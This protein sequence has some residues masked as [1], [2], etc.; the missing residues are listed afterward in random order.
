MSSILNIGQTALA[1][2]QAGL[3]TT[4]H[5][6]ANASTPGYNRQIV[7]QAAL[8]GQN[9]GFGFVGRGTEIASI[10]RVYSDFL[11]NQVV[12]S[13]SA[14]SRLDS[15][16]T[17]AKYIDSLVAD[18]KTGVS[19]ALQNF[20]KSVQNISGSP[21]GAEARQ[22]LLSSS[23][24]LVAN[25]RTLD[26]QLS[27]INAGINSEITAS[28]TTINA[29]AKQLSQLN[30]AIEKAQGAMGSHPAND[31]L[32]RRDQLITDLAKEVNVSVVK[33]G[34]SYNVFIGN[35]QPLVMGIQTF[36]LTATPHPT[37]KQRIQ[38]GYAANG[39]NV[40]LPESTLTGGRLGGLLEFRSRTLD[41]TQ[42][43]LGRMAAALTMDFNAQHQLGL[44]QNGEMGGDFFNV[45]LQTQSR[46]NLGDGVVTATLVDS[47]ALTASDYRIQY[48]GSQ[49]HLTRLS[50][51]KNL[52]S[53]ATVADLGPVDGI[54]LGFTGSSEVGESYLIRPTASFISKLGVAVTNKA[55]IA[56][57]VPIATSAPLT[58]T[59]TAKISTG[60][61][62]QGF[63]PI[64]SPITLTFD[65]SDGPTGSLSGFPADAA[66]T[67]IVNGVESPPTTPG[68]PVPYTAG[69]TY[70][71][72]GMEI[73]LTGAP[74]DGD[75]FQIVHNQNVNGD[76]RNAVLLG[77]LQEKNM[78]AGGMT[79]QGAYAQMVSMIGN[80]TREVEVTNAGASKLYKQAVE[81]QQSMSGVNLDEEAS[82]LIRYQQAY[83]AA[84]K[85]MQTA[86]QM[87]ET[88]LEISR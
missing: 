55:D 65:A 3:A 60:A 7:V 38:I 69:A 18:P 34:N 47:S 72:N 80:V 61:V 45:D 35:G 29:Y 76:G 16:Y 39:A 27:E 44:T 59:G 32:D 66:V 36:G 78:I 11:A 46:S 26:Q 88:L 52:G 54:T 82:N 22:T 42:N 33:H 77:T 15:Y 40:V 12:S 62:L 56:V 83:Q 37:E 57:A 25:F 50:D 1:A 75:E 28:V 8:A 67:V 13:Q 51:G 10:T 86:T 79:Y 19:P 64:A 85:V 24:S 74:G 31:L 17:Q 84:G 5:N 70:R 49:Y 20:F 87:F 48:D 14:K 9:Q 73:T 53:A 63:S 68:D 21:N 30:D 41:A 43:E 23:N 71:F 81:A 58:N 6:V 4:G 2:A